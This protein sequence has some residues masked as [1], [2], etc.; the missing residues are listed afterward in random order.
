MLYKY[1]GPDQ[2]DE[3]MRKLSLELNPNLPKVRPEKG[4]EFL[5]Q[6]LDTP[7]HMDFGDEVKRSLS[8]CQTALLVIDATREFV[9]HSSFVTSV[10][11]GLFLKDVSLSLH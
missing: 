8:A 11:L 5:L 1:P 4:Q 6:M 9:C 10:L 3:E 2:E 7:G